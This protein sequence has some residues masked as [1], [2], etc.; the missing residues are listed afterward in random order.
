[1]PPKFETSG[2][3]LLLQRLIENKELLFNKFDDSKGITKEKRKAKWKEIHEE[4]AALGYPVG[5]DGD[6]LRDTTFS[7]LKK[8]TLVSFTFMKQSISK[9]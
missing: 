8:R 1:M 7:N 2:K 5:R 3:K 6:Y 4:M 9:L